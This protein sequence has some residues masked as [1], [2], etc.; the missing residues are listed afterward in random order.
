MKRYSAAL[1]AAGLLALGIGHAQAGTS[2]TNI[3]DPLNTTFTQALGINR[4]VS[5]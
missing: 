4:C 2:F 1:G 3:I 5:R